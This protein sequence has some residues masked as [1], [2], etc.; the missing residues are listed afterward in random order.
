MSQINVPSFFSPLPQI[1]VEGNLLRTMKQNYCVC[2]WVRGI[3][4]K[5][6]RH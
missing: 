5:P 6:S 4:A 3:R 2:Y 1:P